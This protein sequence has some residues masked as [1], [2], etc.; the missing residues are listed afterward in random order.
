MRAASA[1]LVCGL[2]MSVSIY[3]RHS[4]R[5]SARINFSSCSQ[6]T[7]Y[8]HAEKL[9]GNWYLCTPEGHT[10]F[11][12]GVDAVAPSPDPSAEDPYRNVV[13]KYGDADANW[14]EITARR[15]EQWGF[16]TLGTYTSPYAEPTYLSRRYPADGK[17]LH[18][19]PTKLPFVT[20]IRPGYYAMKNGGGYLAE[21]VKDFMYGSSPFY[22]GHVP[23]NGV[24]DYFDGNLASWLHASLSGESYW[25]QLRRSPYQS[26]LIGIACEDGDQIYGFGAGDQFPTEPNRGFNNPHLGWIIATVSPIQTANAVKH[27]VYKDTA[28]YTK[29]AWRD[30]LKSRYGTIEA[31]NRAWNANYTTFDSAGAQISDEYVGTGD[32]KTTTFSHHLSSLTPSK[33]SIQFKLGSKTVAGDAKQQ[34]SSGGQLSNQEGQI[35]GPEVDG[36]VD[37]TR[38]VAVL[39]FKKAPLA[40]ERITTSYVQNGWGIGS[41]LLDEDGRPGH[42]NWLGKNFRTLSDSN[43]AVRSDLNSELAAVSAHFFNTCRTEIKAAFPHTLYL[44]P[45]TLGSYGVP[46]RPEVL[47]SASKYIDV[48]LLAGTGGFS[49]KALDYVER[50]SHDK[51]FI[52]T[53]FRAANPD[54]D[55]AGYPMDSGVPGFAS[56]AERGKDYQHAL[57]YVRD[58]ATSSGTH[59]YVGLLWWQYADNWDEKL[60]WGLVTLLDNAYDGHEDVSHSIACSPPMQAL[61][62][63]GET[64]NY[65]DLISAVRGANSEFHSY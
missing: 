33:F 55:F 16:N 63:G 52:E 48:L 3:S 23:S 64:R 2:L 58:A 47:E 61:K 42:R 62:C 59:P 14:G 45:D 26:L 32:G 60:N 29:L 13:A 19:H 34:A 11:I 57:A 4:G 27:A 51:P 35:F 39:T 43:A 65:G 50:Y 8:F 30:Y 46:P 6:A 54:S 28:V 21:P 20:L 5:S 38:G 36:H 31:L 37:Y 22:T 25:A 56:Q 10:F 41:G 9:N 24:P 53:T 7:G 40:G 12:I 49:R 17:G 44:G 18:S 1:I 15:L